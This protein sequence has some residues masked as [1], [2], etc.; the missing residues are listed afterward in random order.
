MSGTQTPRK[1]LPA[2]IKNGLALLLALAIVELM[3]FL[4]FSTQHER[5][6]FYRPQ[7]FVVDR[8][9]LEKIESAYDPLLGWTRPFETRFNERPRARQYERPLISTFGDSFTYGGDVNDDQ[10]YQEYLSGML[11]ADVFNFGVSAF[12]TDQAYLRFWRDY[13]K[14]GTPI[15]ILGLISENI[16]RTANAFRPFYSPDTQYTFTKPRYV[17]RRGKRVLLTNP[18][19]SRE[20]LTKLTELDFLLEV[21]RNDYWFNHSQ[22]PVLSFPYTR[23]LWNRRLWSQLLARHADRQPDDVD[24]T[25]WAYI[26]DD[27]EIRSVYFSILDSFV[28]DAERL[29]AEPIILLM[30]QR[31]ELNQQLAG[32][33]LP[34]FDHLRQYCRDN[35]RRCFDGAAQL[36]PLV[37]TEEDARKLV[38]WHFTVRGNYTLAGLLHQYLSDEGLLHEARERLDA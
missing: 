23:L 25:P 9:A 26:W 24:P 27:P 16:N 8:K 34:G 18:V 36:A 10:T 22:Y 4:L 15:V 2:S 31:W 11:E 12:G 14:V 1:H 35:G 5:F 20:E 37:K 7:R 6:T 19:K 3:S 32:E 38:Q 28:E 21:G 17:I 13:P 33:S 29:G 30:P